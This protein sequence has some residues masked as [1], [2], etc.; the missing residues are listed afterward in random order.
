MIAFVEWGPLRRPISVL[1][2]FITIAAILLIVLTFVAIDG[3]SHSA[4][5]TLYGVYP[6]FGVTFLL[7][8]WLARRLSRS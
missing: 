6:Y 1:G 7:W 2:W 4:S 5:D 3:R 8:D